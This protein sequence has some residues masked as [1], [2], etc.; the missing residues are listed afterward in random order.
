MGCERITLQSEVDAVADVAGAGQAA[1]PA[2]STFVIGV[3]GPNDTGG[4]E[5]LDSIAQ[6]GGTQRAFIVDTAGNVAM[7]FRDALNKIRSARLSCELL[8][9]EAEAGKTLDFKQ[10]NVVVDDGRGPATLDY[11]GEQG[12]CGMAGGWYYDVNPD[13]PVSGTP[14]RIV[15][16]PSTCAKFGEIAT[17]SVQIKLGCVTRVPVK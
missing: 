2:I 8:V 10:V 16:C 3:M 4:R 13:P 7:Q 5:T 15:A 12:N 9:P 6:A 1:T 17:G 11:V 14:E